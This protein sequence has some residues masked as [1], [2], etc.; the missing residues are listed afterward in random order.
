M[1]SLDE[2]CIHYVSIMHNK[3]LSRL[4]SDVEKST[5]C[6]LGMLASRSGR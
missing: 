5:F 4:T 2:R 1:S 3:L 6:D